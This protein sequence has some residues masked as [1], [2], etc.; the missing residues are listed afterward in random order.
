[1]VGDALRSEVEVELSVN[2][3]IGSKR[4]S[5]QGHRAAISLA[6]GLHPPLTVIRSVEEK[7]SR[8]INGRVWVH[9]ALD[10]RGQDEDLEC[11]SGLAVALCGEVELLVLVSRAGRHGPD[12]AGTRVDGDDCRG[13]VGAVGEGRVDRIPARLLETWI[14]RRIDL[15]PTLLDRV[16]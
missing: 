14:D 3:V 2:R 11:R 4:R 10:R 1:G 5:H 15:E 16:D 9:A 12:V 8:D 13:R 6:V 7:R